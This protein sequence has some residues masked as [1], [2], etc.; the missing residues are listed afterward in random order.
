M[1]GPAHWHLLQ[2]QAP[3]ALA[4]SSS[5]LASVCGATKPARLALSLSAAAETAATATVAAVAKIAKVAVAVEVATVA[6][7]L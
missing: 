6:P 3:L 2:A 5:E 1:A 7:L 4:S